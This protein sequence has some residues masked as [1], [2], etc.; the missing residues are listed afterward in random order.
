MAKKLGI[1]QNKLL[2]RF[3]SNIAVKK[4]Y[5]ETVIINQTKQWLKDNGIDIDQLESVNR[6]KC[7]R[8]KSIILVKNIPYS[9]KE[10]DLNE[11]FSRYGKLKRLSVSPFNT[12]GIVEYEHSSQAASA[13]KYLAYYKINYISP[14]YLEYAPKVF[15]NIGK[16]LDKEEE[17]DLSEK[18]QENDEIDT[19]KRMNTIFVKNLNFSTTE[20]SLEEVFRNAVSTA[21]VLSVKIIRKSDN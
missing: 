15:K 16:S 6:S 18:E 3:D 11:I 9:T 10:K 20:N 2:D 5:A 13:M 8:S 21:K 1:D 17:I 12:I 7:S 4:A 19:K 14:I